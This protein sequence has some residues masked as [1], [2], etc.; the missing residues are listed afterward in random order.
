MAEAGLEPRYVDRPT[1]DP[2][3]VA[4][5]VGQELRRGRRFS[6]VVAANDTI[7]IAILGEL[8]RAAYRFRQPSP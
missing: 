8:E 6:A 3:T 7:A 1:Q 5:A 2:P 4:A